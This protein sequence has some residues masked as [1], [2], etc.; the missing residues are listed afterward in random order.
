MGDGKTKEGALGGK[1]TKR[2]GNRGKSSEY[3]SLK[4]CGQH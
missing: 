1:T 2:L 3:A 4:R